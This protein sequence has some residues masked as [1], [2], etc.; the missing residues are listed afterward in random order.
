M[1]LLGHNSDLGSESQLVLLSIIIVI[2]VASI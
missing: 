2:V 1:A